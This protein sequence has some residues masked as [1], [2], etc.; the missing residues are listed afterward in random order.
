MRCYSRSKY[1][2]IFDFPAGALFTFARF[3]TAET[4][5][6]A[7]FDPALLKR[8][9]RKIFPAVIMKDRPGGGRINLF[10]KAVEQ[11][12]CTRSGVRF[13]ALYI[14]LII[15]VIKR[16]CDADPFVYKIKV[17]I[18]KGCLLYTSRCV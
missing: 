4:G 9:K 1:D 12:R 11:D 6:T 2:L 17:L 10:G 8:R 18:F 16:L 13:R 14:Y 5:G 7:I 15:F 3:F